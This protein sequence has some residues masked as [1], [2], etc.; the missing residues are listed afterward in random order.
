VGVVHRKT[1]Y[2]F[3][4]G[5]GHPLTKGVA[6]I[7]GISVVLY[8]V[9]QANREALYPLFGF[10]PSYAI[11]KLRIWQFITANFMHGNLTHLIFNMLGL[12]M[13]GC[14]VEKKVG[15]LEFIKYFL[16]CGIGGYILAFILWAIGITP[17]N[18]IVGASAG[19]YGLLLAF[20]LLYPNQ[21]ILLFF[22]IPMQA[23][24]MAVIFGVLE[25]LLMFRNDGISHIGHLGGILAG[26][27]YLIYV[28]ALNVSK[29]IMTVS[30]L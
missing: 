7:G 18:L 15:Q 9:T 29:M 24:W 20:S 16:V 5:M 6:I 25:F 27:G 12:Y 21:K 14:P 10:I 2:N 28:K 3:Q 13:F 30:K 22:L 4:L 11:S 8:I 19:V 26:I 23:K 17:N 1:Q